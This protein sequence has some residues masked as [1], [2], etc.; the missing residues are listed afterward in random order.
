MARPERGEKTGA[1]LWILQAVVALAAL[2]TFRSRPRR[3]PGV[4]LE[5]LAEGYEHSDI[6]PGVVLGGA[7][8][9]LVVVAVVVVA[10]TAFEATV[11]GVPPRITPPDELIQE[12][13][14]GPA[15]Q[16]PRPALEAQAGQNLGPYLAAQRRRLS[17]YRWVNRQAGVV[18]I[19]IDRAMDV[20][21]EEGLPARPAPAD[22]G[23]QAPS[24]SSSGRVD[25]AYP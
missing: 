17:T 13:Q 16:L 1:L 11:T 21:A 6:R 25:E 19:P 2:L 8:A 10:V 24:V 20:I 9:L 7:A 4:D 5:D 12:L 22:L 3:P 23:N 14:G 18:A 15:P